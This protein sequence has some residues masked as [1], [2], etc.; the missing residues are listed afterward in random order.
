MKELEIE[1]TCGVCEKIQKIAEGSSSGQVLTY[2]LETSSNTRLK[3][4]RA[5][6]EEL[7]NE[8]HAITFV[9]RAETH[10][11]KIKYK[12]RINEKRF[13]K[14]LN[15]ECNPEH[16]PRKIGDRVQ[17]IASMRWG[18][19]VKGRPEYRCRLS[20]RRMKFI[21]NL[22]YGSD[23]IP[24]RNG[25]KMSTSNKTK[26]VNIIND[27]FMSSLGFDKKLVEGDGGRGYYLNELV[28]IVTPDQQYSTEME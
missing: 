19:F 7:A 28:Y 21:F 18:L 20:P 10:L 3:K 4:E 6:L 15:D 2:L 9:G 27:Q 11:N 13:Q 1:D 5:C 25:K 17:I 14:H 8:Y 16:F 12:F 22:M 23:D 24:T 26:A